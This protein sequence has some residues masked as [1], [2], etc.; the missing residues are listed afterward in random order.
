[1][2]KHAISGYRYYRLASFV[3]DLSSLLTWYPSTLIISPW[4]WAQWASCQTSHRSSSVRKI[5]TK[6]RRTYI[7]LCNEKHGTSVWPQWSK[8]MMK[9]Q[10]SRFLESIN[11]N[12]HQHLRSLIL[13]YVPNYSVP[14]SLQSL[15]N[16]L[17]IWTNL[18]SF[19]P[20]RI[21]ASITS[22]L[23]T[24]ICPRV[25]PALI[26]KFQNKHIDIDLLFRESTN[27]YIISYSHTLPTPSTPPL[28]HRHRRTSIFM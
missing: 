8:S 9:V 14:D 2:A 7:I 19:I 12:C 17:L 5:A 21:L 25:N 1:M 6:S 22:A 11:I 20:S 10:G 27:S 24:S 4:R 15:W 23:T 3:P 26:L 13:I 16:F 18:P 28:T